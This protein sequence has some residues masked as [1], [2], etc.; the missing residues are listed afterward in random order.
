[1]TTG[2]LGGFARMAEPG[3][4]ASIR[5]MRGTGSRLSAR[6]TAVAVAA[7]ALGTACGAG[8][9]GGAPTRPAAPAAGVAAATPASPPRTIAYSESSGGHGVPHVWLMNVATGARRQLTRGPYGEDSPSWS[10]AGTRLA[11]AQ[12]RAGVRL[13]GLSA[14]QITSQIVIRDMASGRV[15]TLT[16][17]GLEAQT[18]AWSPHGDR[19]AYVETPVASGAQTT[20]PEIWTVGTNGRGARQLTHNSVSDATPTLS[21]AGGVIAFARERTAGAANWDIWTMRPDGSGQR[22]LA[23]NGMKPAFS[24]SGRL[25]AFGQPSGGWTACCQRADLMVM[26][27]S[28]HHRRLLV[29]NGNGPSWSPDGS[30]IVFYRLFKHAELWVVRADGTGLRRLTSPAD[31]AYGPEWRPR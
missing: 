25:I 18:P 2:R 19:I 22:L 1:M 4:G 17:R 26:D 24:P 9:A 11:Y 7:V 27:A 30:Q 31:H 16:A 8:G 23:R 28:G 6:I 12:T 21:P 14:P 10:P 5:A 13:P 29:K 15:T 20:Y 3:V